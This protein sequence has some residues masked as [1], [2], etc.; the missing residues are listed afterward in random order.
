MLIEPVLHRHGFAEVLYEIV[1]PAI[2][3]PEAPAG[4]TER[5]YAHIWKQIVDQQLRPG[6]RVLDAAIAAQLGISR[7]PV[8]QAIQ[9]LIQDGLLEPLARGVRVWQPAADQVAELYDYR[10]A[11]EAF[12][13]RRT[14][15]ELHVAPLGEQLHLIRDLR[16][17]FGAPDWRHDPQLAVDFARHDV[18]LHQLVMV[19]LGNRYVVRA[20]AAIYGRMALF[21]IASGRIPGR[22]EQTLDEHEAIVAALLGQDPEQAAAAVERHIQ[23]VKRSVLADFFW[24]PEPARQHASDGAG[25]PPGAA[26]AAGPSTESR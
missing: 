21:G 7:T 15:G 26:R 5:A 8:R 25:R 10:T 4:E 22:M 16:A 2:Q 13:V 1:W 3:H 20:L 6:E 23:R 19:G 24:Q 14:A 18:G 9:R 17:R 11:L 12:A